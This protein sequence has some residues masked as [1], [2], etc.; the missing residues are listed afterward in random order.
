MPTLRFSIVVSFGRPA[1]TAQSAPLSL[2]TG[3]HTAYTA[4]HTPNGNDIHH[5][6]FTVTPGTLEGHIMRSPRSRQMIRDLK[7]SL[8]TLLAERQALT[9]REE[10]L[11]QKLNEVLPAM[12]YRVARRN[13]NGAGPRAGSGPKP[14]VCD[15]CSR[16]FARP[17]H[18]GRHVSA[19]HGKARKKKAA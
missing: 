13:S 9:A 3:S 6:A 11:I 14:L 10:Q 18:L 12:G 2:Y 1:A 16:R 4:G 17:L 15:V 8:E 7:K 5:L 19:A